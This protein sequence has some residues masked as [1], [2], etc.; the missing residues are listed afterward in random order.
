MNVDH[1]CHADVMWMSDDVISFIGIV[2]TLYLLVNM[3]R[4]WSEPHD[5]YSIALDRRVSLAQGSLSPHPTTFLD[6]MIN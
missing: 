2:S 3:H 1:G 4:D 6:E 5:R